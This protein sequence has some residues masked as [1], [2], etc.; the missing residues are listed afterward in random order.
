MF[1]PNSRQPLTH[2]H[3]GLLRKNKML[4][5]V[6]TQISEMDGYRTG[7]RGRDKKSAKTNKDMHSF[8][9]DHSLNET[10]PFHDS[11]NRKKQKINVRSEV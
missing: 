7:E 2:S 1:S 9:K 5:A 10:T 4:L 6:K 3:S 11:S 8:E